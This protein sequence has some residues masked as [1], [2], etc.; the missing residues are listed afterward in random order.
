VAWFHGN[1]EQ[2]A[3]VV[4]RAV[5]LQSRGLG[6][7]AIEYPGYGLAGRFETTEEHVYAD[8]QAA[9][10]FAS[11]EL[12]VASGDTVLWGQSLGTGVATEMAR[13]G[14]GGRL[15]LLSPM[16]SMVDM[17]RRVVPFLPVSVLVRD[18]YES[19]TKAADIALPSLVVHGARDGVIPWRMGRRMADALPH[20]RWEL[21]DGAG[22]NDLFLVGGNPLWDML[23]DFVQQ[24]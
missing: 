18:R 1:G 11:G 23:V 7:L 4:P 9:L 17:A 15:V 13:R 5:A 12:G 16:T 2:V 19:L 20:C 6:V 22:H 24:R 10:A 14:L 21:I 8:A 3:D